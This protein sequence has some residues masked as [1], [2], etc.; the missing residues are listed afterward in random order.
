MAITY[1]VSKVTNPNGAEE[2]NYYSCKAIKTSDY[3]FNDLVNDIANATTVTKADALAVL[4]SIKPY[5]K[6]ALLAGR[7]VV[8]NDLGSIVIGLRGK[9]F[10]QEDMNEKDFSPSSKIKGHSV[11]FRLEP[12]LKR[13]IAAGISLKR[14]S[15]EAMK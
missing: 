7:R 6:Q 15:S 13:E 8:L 2:V 10:T 11:R 3:S 14:I 1:H 12:E 4:A 9:C 5:I